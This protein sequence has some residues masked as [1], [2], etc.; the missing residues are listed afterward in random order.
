MNRLN[1]KVFWS[2]LVLLILASSA[3]ATLLTD[4][5]DARSWQGATVGTFAE[6]IYGS[7]TLANRQ[8]IIDDKLLGTEIKCD[9]CEESF[10]A[11]W[12]EPV[13]VLPKPPEADSEPAQDEQAASP[14]TS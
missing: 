5:N 13:M 14:S 1:S 8:Q 6:L 9:S 11:D 10:E 12:G 4:P 2:L 3:N 7:N